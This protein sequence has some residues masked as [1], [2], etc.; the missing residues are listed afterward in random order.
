MVLFV[1][2]GCGGDTNPESPQSKP[3]TEA[4]STL[5][6]SISVP[7]GNNAEK[8]TSV[9]ALKQRLPRLEE[10][11]DSEM[12][13]VVASLNLVPS[14]CSMCQGRTAA[15]CLV[16]LGWTE[17]RVLG[18]LADRAIRLAKEGQGVEQIKIAVN[19]PDQWFPGMGEGTP[20]QI[21]LYRDL[22]GSFAR[23]TEEI[24]TRV[25]EIFGEQVEIVT[26][27]DPE[28][29]VGHLDIRSRPTWFVNG[30]R[31]RGVQSVNGI[32]RFVSYEL[33]D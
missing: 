17:C 7:M 28:E 15:H 5:K 31:F 6:D 2:W 26:H 22:E 20:V 12:Q 11:K 14:P 1:L 21:H 18:K 23:Q 24:R 29:P 33:T 19:Y 30:H 16:D 9:V 25:V 8:P 10:L 27:D 4:T 32:A 13:A 3:V